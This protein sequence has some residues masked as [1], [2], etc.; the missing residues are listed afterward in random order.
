MRIEQSL[1]TRFV[2]SCAVQLASATRKHVATLQ[3]VMLEGAAIAKEQ[4]IAR[5]LKGR[6][7]V[8]TQP[9]IRFKDYL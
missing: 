9:E 3:A 5:Y 2:V 7:S 1:V 4:A 6:V 8:Q